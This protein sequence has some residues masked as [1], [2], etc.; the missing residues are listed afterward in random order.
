MS[1]VRN[2][3]IPGCPHHSREER[4][5]GPEISHEKLRCSCKLAGVHVSFG[6]H[7]CHP[8]TGTAPS[9]ERGKEVT[10]L[11][12]IRRVVA[13]H[14]VDQVDA[15]LRCIDREK[16]H[17][18]RRGL[19]RRPVQESEHLRDIASTQ[20]EPE[21]ASLP[22]PQGTSQYRQNRDAPRSRESFTR[23]PSRPGSLW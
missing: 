20:S 4:T 21:D 1:F 13:L 17:L 12:K 19:L 23:G 18:V 3:E 8:V 10:G 9:V 5:A 16:L 2:R 6:I 11:G 15:V 14:G 22:L 7:I